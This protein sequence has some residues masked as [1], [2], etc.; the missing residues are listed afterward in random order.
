[1][2]FVVLAAFSIFISTSAFASEAGMFLC[3]SPVVAGDFWNDL[4]AA[5][6]AGVKLNRE[7]AVGTAQK[8]GCQFVAGNNLKPTNFVA[9]ELAITDGTVTGWAAP[10]LYIMYVNGPTSAN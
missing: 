1:M 8:N 5:Q 3:R 2:R 9:G 7:I 6:Q 10:Q 4:L